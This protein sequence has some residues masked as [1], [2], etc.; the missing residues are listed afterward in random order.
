[1]IESWAE[2]TRSSE[3]EF[4]SSR[5]ADRGATIGKKGDGIVLTF[6]QKRGIKTVSFVVAFLLEETK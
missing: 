2:A 5:Q 3:C 1:M 4:A 6:Y